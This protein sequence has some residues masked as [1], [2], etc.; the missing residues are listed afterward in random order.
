MPAEYFTM[1]RRV[2]YKLVKKVLWAGVLL[3]LAYLLELL[4]GCGHLV[5]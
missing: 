2:I 4:C 5:R 3:L 1:L